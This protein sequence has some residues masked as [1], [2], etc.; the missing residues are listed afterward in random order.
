M[1]HRDGLR[2]IDDMNIVA[3]AEDVRAHL[4]IP[5][6]GLMAEVDAS[7]QKLTHLKVRKRHKSSPVDLP[8]TVVSPFGPPDGL[9][10]PLSGPKALRPRE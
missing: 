5:T 8:R 2:Q 7:F 10:D 3:G 1:Q 6:V 4:R 9:F